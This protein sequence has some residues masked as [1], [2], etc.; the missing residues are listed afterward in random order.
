MKQTRHKH[1]RNV[2]FRR[3]DKM[4][5]SVHS[6]SAG[7]TLATSTALMLLTTII[8]SSSTTHAGTSSATSSPSSS[9]PIRNAVVP[10]KTRTGSSPR[11]RTILASTKTALRRPRGQSDD[12]NFSDVDIN[13]A[14]GNSDGED[15][16]GRSETVVEVESV[17][18]RSKTN[19]NVDAGENSSEWTGGEWRR[20]DDWWKDPLALFDDEDEKNSVASEE[21]DTTKDSQINEKGV[22]TIVTVLQED[23]NIVG[24]DGNISDDTSDPGTRK[25]VE[26]EDACSVDD[27]EEIVCQSKTVKD[28]DNIK[29][30]VPLPS[31]D[32]T[33]IDGDD[34][35]NNVKKVKKQKK[36]KKL[37][38][39]ITQND[40]SSID[41]SDENANTNKDEDSISVT[42]KDGIPTF[43]EEDEKKNNLIIEE[44]GKSSNIVDSDNDAGLLSQTPDSA[45]TM[46]VTP[47][48]HNNKKSRSN[49]IRSG[50]SI[51]SSRSP[52]LPVLLLGRSFVGSG[53]SLWKGEKM[54]G[55][56]MLT[57]I[58][59]RWILRAMLST[60]AAFGR[61]DEVDIDGN[62]KDGDLND[63]TEIEEEEEEEGLSRE[64]II[65]L[66]KLGFQIS[67]EYTSSES[68]DNS[69]NGRSKDEKSVSRGRKQDSKKK[70]NG[71]GER[72]RRGKNLI[73][74]G[75]SRKGRFRLLPFLPQ[76]SNRKQQKQTNVYLE[77]ELMELTKEIEEAKT[78]RYTLERDQESSSKTVRTSLSLRLFPVIFHSFRCFCGFGVYRLHDNHNFPI[79]LLFNLFIFQFTLTYY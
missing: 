56:I 74:K 36:G 31:V 29:G 71:T 69:T 63:T 12:K 6:I 49:A 3:Q 61:N 67:P 1:R 10:I 44:K 60:A 64:E 14:S 76:A 59:G 65:T 8:V 72:K 40:V 5:S 47:H 38:L 62:N 54:G 43:P 17:E 73:T 27:D 75:E 23:A 30:V 41:S 77:A 13:N 50:K 22:T 32:T 55:K 68:P 57:F 53:G 79:Q 11:F 4:T 46:K 2:S 42:E 52:L 39:P 78:K 24:R 70:E 37:V 18:K 20:Y 7:P 9:S 19:S 48:K 21:K 66:E 15:R 51:S 16:R 28:N 45:T 35:F 34:E 25:R 33:I 58:L 26:G